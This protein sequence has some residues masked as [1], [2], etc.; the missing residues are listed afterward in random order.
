MNPRVHGGCCRFSQLPTSHLQV[1]AQTVVEADS[2]GIIARARVRVE[3]PLELCQQPVLPIHNVRS[4]GIE[5][6]AH[7]V[8]HYV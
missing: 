5:G 3:H 8:V 2:F 1:G 6:T 4:A 7:I